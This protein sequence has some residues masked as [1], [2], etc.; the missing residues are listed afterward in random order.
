MMMVIPSMGIKNK[1]KLQNMWT[2]YMEQVGTK[3]T[4]MMGREYVDQSVIGSCTSK[5]KILINQTSKVKDIG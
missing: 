3:I 2:K 4:W 1:L 5:I